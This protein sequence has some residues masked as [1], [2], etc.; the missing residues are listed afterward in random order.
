MNGTAMHAEKLDLPDG[1]VIFYPAFFTKE[2]SDGYFQTLADTIDWGQ[3]RINLFGKSIEA[4]RLIA[5]YGDPGKSYSYSRVKHEP[6]PWNEPLLAIKHD[7][8]MVCE[9]AFNSVLLNFYRSERD[10]VSWHSDDEPELGEN[11]VIGSVSFGGS[12][13]F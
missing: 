2:A 3:E 5:W 11:P 9:A 1:D 10:S 8:E 4:P 13:T 12:R 7:I 6:L